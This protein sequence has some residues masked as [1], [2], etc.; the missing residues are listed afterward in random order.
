MQV[1]GMQCER[2]Q[3]TACRE[4]HWGR[5]GATGVMIWGGLQGMEG[6]VGTQA[7]AGCGM[8][9]SGWGQQWGGVGGIWGSCGAARGGGQARGSCVAVAGT[10][11]GR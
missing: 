2:E 8:E 9:M 4:D 11:W 3:G 5:L 1:L 10:G 6:R 7:R